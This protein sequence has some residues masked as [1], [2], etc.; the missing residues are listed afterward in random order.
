M[1][2]VAVLVRPLVNDLNKLLT[3]SDYR[4]STFLPHPKAYRRPPR[5]VMMTYSSIRRVALVA[6][7]AHDVK[8]TVSRYF[9]GTT[10]LPKGQLPSRVQGNAYPIERSSY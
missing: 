3:M 6:A 4:P 7:R 10:L 5:K 8:A 9:P 2:F 1:P